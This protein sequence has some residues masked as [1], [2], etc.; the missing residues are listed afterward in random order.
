MY[1]DIGEL[2]QTFTHLAKGNALRKKLLG[3]SIDQDKHFFRKLKESQTKLLENKL[4]IGKI[5]SRVSPIFILGMPRSGTTIVEQI[6][7]AHSEV[8][9]AG[10][11]VHVSQ[12]GL[13]LIQEP[14]SINTS[15]LLK[16]RKNYLSQVSKLSNVKRFVTDKMPQNFRFIPLICAALPEAKIIHVKR[17]AAAICWSNYRTY[18]SSKGLGYCYNLKDV[19]EYYNLYED[20]MKLW[21]LHYDD[22][23]FHLNYE[24]LIANQ[25]DQ[26]RKLIQYLELDWEEACLSPHQNKRSVKTAS[27]EQVRQ[28]LYKGSSEAWLRFEKILN[29]AFDK[30]PH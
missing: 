21:Q 28:K 20:L 11:L 25:Y 22:R 7:S 5:S 10:E 29:G 23:I 30:L 14:A 2:D 9:G 1:D 27:Q 12:L 18:F 6:I 24:N 17:N 3:Y 4:E 26:T 16:F 19:V 13:K 8:L 15:A